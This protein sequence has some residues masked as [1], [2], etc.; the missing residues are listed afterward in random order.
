MI[1]AQGTLNEKE[2]LLIRA[3]ALMHD[4]GSLDDRRNH[5]KLG[6]RIAV[7]FCRNKPHIQESINPKSLASMITSHRKKDGREK[8]TAPGNSEGCGYS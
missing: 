5:P 3:A 1:Q 6:A 8:K 7:E 4:I 2:A